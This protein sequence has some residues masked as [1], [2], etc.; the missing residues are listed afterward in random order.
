MPALR[1]RT[2]FTVRSKSA[3]LLRAEGDPVVADERGAVGH[4]EHE[5]RLRPLLALLGPPFGGDAE[6]DR[7]HVGRLPLEERGACARQ[8]R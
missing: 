8:H 3:V 4:H 6:V 1:K 7:V 2:R 5:S